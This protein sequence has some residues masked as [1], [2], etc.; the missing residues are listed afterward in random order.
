MK[1]PRGCT[2][3]RTIWALEKVYA[4]THGNPASAANKSKSKIERYGA[5]GFGFS[6]AAGIPIRTRAWNTSPARR[7]KMSP[8]LPR[9][10][11]SWLSSGTVL[12]FVDFARLNPEGKSKPL[13]VLDAWDFLPPGG[14][15][16]CARS[17]S[18]DEVVEPRYQPLIDGEPQLVVE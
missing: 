7:A 12:S 6:R 11:P 3:R 18:P 2:A 9:S 10:S 15:E 17:A 4:N 13:R 1:G 14:T 8:I 16:R 5:C